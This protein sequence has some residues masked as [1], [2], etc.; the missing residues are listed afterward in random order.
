MWLENGEKSHKREL[1]KLLKRNNSQKRR[2]IR[3]GTYR[4]HNRMSDDDGDENLMKLVF[5]SEISVGNYL[6]VLAKFNLICTNKTM[7]KIHAL[8][9]EHDDAFEVE[10][11]GN[12]PLGGESELDRQRQDAIR[13]KYATF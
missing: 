12:P 13:W 3:I 5:Y 11:N 6:I 1:A 9:Y 10:S 4:T 7:Y 8:K 2:K